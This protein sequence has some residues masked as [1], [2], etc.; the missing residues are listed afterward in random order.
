MKIFIYRKIRK[1]PNETTI[2]LLKILTLIGRGSLC[3]FC[4]HFLSCHLTKS[5]VNGLGRGSR[6]SKTAFETQLKIINLHN[7]DNEADI[8][9]SNLLRKN[10]CSRPLSYATLLREPLESR[11][12]QFTAAFVQLLSL[13]LTITIQN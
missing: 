5:I 8:K 9:T 12:Q 1:I 4:E 7:G 2:N 3:A 6:I 11:C 13:G 10:D